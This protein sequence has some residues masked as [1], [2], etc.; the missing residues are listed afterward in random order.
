[1]MILFLILT[2]DEM[3]VALF[4]LK[5]LP[6][7]MTIAQ[8]LNLLLNEL[9]KENPYFNKVTLPINLINDRHI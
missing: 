2:Y 6:E 4:L 9:K 3:F 7:A 1:M 8:L 5:S